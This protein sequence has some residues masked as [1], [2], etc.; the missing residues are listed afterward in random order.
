M[1]RLTSTYSGGFNTSWEIDLWGRI[2]QKVSSARMEALA[3]EEFHR[4]VI[5][6]LVADT[7]QAYFILRE[8]DL[9]LQIAQETFGTRKATHELFR[10]RQ[11]GGVASD[12]EVA[13]AEADMHET[14]AKIPDLQRQISIQ[15]NRICVLLGREPGPVERGMPIADQAR[16]PEIPS[17]GLPSDLLRRRPDIIE[18]EYVV[19]SANAAVGASM[20]EFLPR[21]DLVNFI[22][23]EGRS[24]SDIWGDKTY[25]WTIGGETKLP[26]FHGGRNVYNYRAARAQW[27]QAVSQYQQTVVRAFTDVAN[28]LTDI[29]RLAEVRSAQELQVQ[30]DRRAAELSK[31]RYEGGFSSY[32]EVLDAERR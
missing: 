20:G 28:A 4:G 16:L 19:K 21:L 31:A 23:G 6:T 2:R 18:S 7:A 1:R 9:E 10:Q 3:A 5:I 27:K 29:K 32:L 12:L 8:L 17:A 11:L 22:G 24:P 15:E 25:A 13:Q 14:A 30:A 26:L